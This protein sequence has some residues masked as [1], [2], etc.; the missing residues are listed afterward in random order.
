MVSRTAPGSRAGASSSHQQGLE[1]PKPCF[2]LSRQGTGAAAR[3]PAG[4][5]SKGDQ[6]RA[7]EEACTLQRCP[8]CRERG[9][10]KP[11]ASTALCGNSPSFQLC[12]QQARSSLYTAANMHLPVPQGSKKHQGSSSQAA[13]KGLDAVSCHCRKPPP[14]QIKNM[15][16]A[17]ILKSRPGAPSSSGLSSSADTRGTGTPQERV[18]LPSRARWGCPC[19]LPCHGLDEVPAAARE[20]VTSPVHTPCKSNCPAKSVAPAQPPQLATA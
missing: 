4:P 8:T 3:I 13:G 6:A 2:C 1:H 12:P 5:S 19:L 16:L 15:K 18:Q 17:V 14:C 7:Q 9:H 11:L 10:G 20:A